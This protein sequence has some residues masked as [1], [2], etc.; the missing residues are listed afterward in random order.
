[1]RNCHDPPAGE[2]GLMQAYGRVFAR[3][4]N[5][6]LVDF[7]TQVAPRIL[8]FYA[9][10]SIGQTHRFVLDLCCGTGQLALH[11]LG[12]G[13]TVVG[14]DLSEHMLQ[15]ARQNAS[16]YLASGQVQFIQGDATRFTLA[17]QVGLV[18]STYDALNHLES[19]DA[20]RDCF[21][22]VFAAL[23]GGGL[24]IFDLN[25]RVGLRRWNNINVY[26]RPDTLMILRG[27]FDGQGDRALTKA[28]GF[29]RAPD[30]L[31]ERF[32]ETVFNTVFE[33]RGVRD[34]LRDT[35]WKRVHFARI[36][37]LRTP[38]DDPE[39]EGRVFVVAEK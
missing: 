30:G 6:M 10:T 15:L 22:C 37:D 3:V 5:T 21:R 11:F 25:T 7:V 13:Y 16:Q 4:Y 36:E 18:T 20:L 38:L 35:G 8:E 26:D 12:R 24:F 14:L 31:Y 19:L 1:V 9:N 27:I 28:S 34:A 39:T 32:D 29:A 17:T 33:L 23:T 2:A